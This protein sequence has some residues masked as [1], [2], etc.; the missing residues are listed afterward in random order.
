MSKKLIVGN[1]YIQFAFAM[2]TPNSLTHNEQ[3]LK[4]SAP[5]SKIVF[6]NIWEK[7]YI[8]G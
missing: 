3:M 6:S 4:V 2:A 7:P 5:Y 1:T 8:M